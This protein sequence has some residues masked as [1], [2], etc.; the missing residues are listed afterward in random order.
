MHGSRV[1]RAPARGTSLRLVRPRSCSSPRA[2]AAAVLLRARR[3]LRS[4]SGMPVRTRACRARVSGDGSGRRRAPRRSRWLPCFARGH[5]L[6]RGVAG[7]ADGCSVCLLSL[8]ATDRYHRMAPKRRSDDQLA[9]AARGLA[10]RHRRVG[11]T[12]ATA[13]ADGGDEESGAAEEHALGE[14]PARRSLPSSSPSSAIPSHTAEGSTWLPS[15]PGAAGP[16]AGSAS[17]AVDAAAAREAACI[18]SHLAEAPTPPSATGSRRKRARVSAVAVASADGSSSSVR[19]GK[20]ARVANV[21]SEAAEARLPG[22]HVERQ[23]TSALLSL[24]RPLS[25][26][27]VLPVDWISQEIKR[28]IV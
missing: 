16:F 25:P 7:A 11:T 5:D 3:R 21:V 14:Q 12:S 24:T 19:D 26:M 22:A 18:L 8:I 6:A 1:A 4:S 20:R 13:A 9:A 2:D 17:G 27:C 23:G 10:K 28:F 15:H